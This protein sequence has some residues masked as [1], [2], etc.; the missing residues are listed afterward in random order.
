[1]N[2]LKAPHALGDIVLLGKKWKFYSQMSGCQIYVR[3]L[4]LSRVQPG[5]L[6]P[7]KKKKRSQYK[8]IGSKLELLN[9]SHT[10]TRNGNDPY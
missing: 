7:E 1:M 6:D 8:R 4:M 5:Q 2:E 9:Y 3:P 10:N